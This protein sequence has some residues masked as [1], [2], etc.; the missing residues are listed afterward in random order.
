MKSETIAAIATA[1]NNSGISIIRI[2]GDDAIDIADKI[3]VA[4][5][6]KKNLKNV[7][8]HTVHYGYIC[9]NN[10]VIDEVLVIVMKAPNTYTREDV[11]EIDCHGGIIVTRKILELILNNGA[12]AAMP[13]EFTKRAFINGRI[14]LSQ[15][16][17]VMDLINSKSELALKSSVNQLKGSVM[18]KISRLRDIIIK[19]VAFVEAALDDPE[20]IEIEGYKQKIYVNAK[21]C[22]EDINKLVNSYDNGKIIKE[23]IDTVI[24]GK[25][26][27]GKSSF[28]NALMGESRAIVTDIAGTTRDI[29]KEEI[30][31][32]GLLLNIMDTAGIRQT[33]DIVEKIG[34]DKTIEYLDKAD[35]VIYIVD[36]S[37]IIDENDKKII[38]KI[39]NR[40]SIILLNKSDLDS[41]TLVEDVA[42]LSDK[43]IITIS[44][45]NNTGI[46]EVTDEIY[47]MFFNGNIDFNDEIFITNARQKS[48]L[49]DAMESLEN[50]I[51]S[52]EDDMPE[53]FYSI[54]MMGAYESLGLVNGESLE[55]DLADTIFREFC[56]GK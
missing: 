8:S 15:A 4:K 43:K 2:S 17:A 26:N 1:V 16:E 19:D 18:E 28:L 21:Q 42:K 33:E 44:A 13:G 7:D 56:M 41:L 34:I 6:K 50:V 53:D 14:D 45:K 32:N 37:T 10:V 48:A 52:I 51:K 36:S 27:A 40:N 31:I 47:N 46:N 29:I 30:N 22:I 24:V 54:D 3:F 49:M 23:G 39:K 55:D 38:E 25:P 9:D 11:V 12:A 5:N 35:L 20:H